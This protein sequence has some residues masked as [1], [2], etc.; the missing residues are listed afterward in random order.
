MGLRGLPERLGPRGL[1]G[2][3]GRMELQEQR[4]LRGLLD[5]PGPRDPRECPAPRDLLGRPG[6]MDLL[7]QRGPRS[8]ARLRSSS[9]GVGDRN[10]PVGR[11]S[12]MGGSERG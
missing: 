7:E 10:D 9:I 1:L 5:R 2:W 11:R 6:P 4:G 8:A 12:F 3:P